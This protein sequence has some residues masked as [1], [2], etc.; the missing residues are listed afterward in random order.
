MPVLNAN[1]VD[2]DQMPLTAALIWV[3]TVSQRPIYGMLDIK[4]LN[5]FW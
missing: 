4:G 3:Y 5:G 1:S 2:P